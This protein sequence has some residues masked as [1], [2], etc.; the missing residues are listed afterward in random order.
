[1]HLVNKRKTQQPNNTRPFLRAKKKIVRS[2]S[3]M[4][5]HTIVHCLDGRTSRQWLIHHAKQNNLG[6]QIPESSNDHCLHIMTMA[7]GDEAADAA[8]FKSLEDKPEYAIFRPTP[9]LTATTTAAATTTST[10]GDV[11]QQENAPSSLSGSSLSSPRDDGS[12][13]SS[14]SSSNL[15]FTSSPL[16]TPP[17]PLLSLSKNRQH[18]SDSSDDDEYAVFLDTK[19]NKDLSLQADNNNSTADAKPPPPQPQTQQQL[20]HE[21]AAPRRREQRLAPLHFRPHF[22][23]SLSVQPTAPEAAVERTATWFASHYNFPPFQQQQQG[24]PVIAVI[25]LGGGYSTTDLHS[26]WTTTLGL[27]TVP[28]VVAYPVGQATVPVFTGGDADNENALDIQIAGALCPNATILF[29]AATNTDTSF[30]SAVFAAT[31][32][33][34]VAGKFYQPSVISISWGAPENEYTVKTVAAFNSLFQQALGRGITVTAAAGDNGSSDGEAAGGLPHVDFPASSPYVV[35]CGGTSVANNKNIETTWSYDAQNKWGTGGGVSTVFPRPVWQLD[36]VPNNINAQTQVVASTASAASP[37]SSL[38]VDTTVQAAA[39]AAAAATDDQDQHEAVAVAT[40]ASSSSSDA[41]ATAAAPVEQGTM[42]AAASGS[43]SSVSSMSA[44]GAAVS[45]SSVSSLLVAAPAGA[46]APAG[47]GVPDIALN[48]DPESGWVISFN[49]RLVTVGGTSCV[50]PAVAGFLALVNLKYMSGFN[51]AL[52]TIWKDTEARPI[53][54]KDITIGS[55][56]DLKTPGLYS[57]GIG[58]DFCTG[59]GAFNGAQLYQSLKELLVKDP[60]IVQNRPVLV[61]GAAGTAA[62][63]PGTGVL[64]PH[65]ALTYKRTAEEQAAIDRAHGWRLLFV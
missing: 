3:R 65:K 31:Y 20:K 36:I 39:A 4:A 54:F 37:S 59:L 19:K 24:G 25:S 32:G 27:A 56:D 40:V 64:V 17:S 55:N 45:S 5:T 35:A 46:I 21:C 26:Y 11:Q 58:Y 14:S 10:N 60:T 7:P 33:V 63:A 2:T 50:A 16:S 48:A 34:T 52:Y 62:S 6:T 9:Q 13:S 44:S 38:V 8:F 61:G 15:S 42:S 47:R 51:A 22:R 49:S 43:S 28:T 1:M 41:V 53:V 12:S 57:A 18:Q 23:K 29:V 30:Y